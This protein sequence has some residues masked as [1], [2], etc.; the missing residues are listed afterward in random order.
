MYAYVCLG[1]FHTG[2]MDGHG[3][4][5]GSAS[6]GSVEPD[7]FRKSESVEYGKVVANSAFLLYGHAI[8]G[9]IGYWIVQ[10]GARPLERD[11][12]ALCLLEA[13]FEARG[14]LLRSQVVGRAVAVLR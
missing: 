6:P 3:D 11:P 8:R 5:G 7:G 2:P 14:A 4:L 13:P 10:R 12:A 9:P 1:R